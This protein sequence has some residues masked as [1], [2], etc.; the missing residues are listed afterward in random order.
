MCKESFA[1]W[2]IRRKK[3]ACN[4]FKI[5]PAPNQKNSLTVHPSSIV[6]KSASRNSEMSCWSLEFMHVDHSWK[7]GHLALV[8]KVWAVTA[9]TVS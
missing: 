6:P 1:G 8:N 4:I 3:S 9:C 2:H 7:L 5:N